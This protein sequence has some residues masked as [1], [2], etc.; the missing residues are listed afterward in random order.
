[1]VQ[2]SFQNVKCIQSRGQPPVYAELLGTIE[3]SKR[4][5]ESMYDMMQFRMYAVVFAYIYIY[6]YAFRVT[7]H[8]FFLLRFPPPFITF[9]II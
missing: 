6:I 3:K 9:F 1:M 4:K 8:N 2:E 7:M 5:F